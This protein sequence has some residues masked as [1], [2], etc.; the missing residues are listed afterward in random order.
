[1]DAY[2]KLIYEFMLN[3]NLID[4]NDEFFIDNVLINNSKENL[5]IKSIFYFD[6]K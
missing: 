2:V 5:K 1:M 6:E 4:I 3:G